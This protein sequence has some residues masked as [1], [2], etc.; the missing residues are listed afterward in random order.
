[1]TKHT[2]APE[3]LPDD[4][5]ATET[6]DALAQRVAKA[7][8]GRATLDA[9]LGI[10][11][12][13]L[14]IGTAVMSIVLSGDHLNFHG[15]VHGGVIFALA[16]SAFAYACN[17]RGVISVAAGCSIEYLC[18][19]AAGEALTATAREEVLS[20]RQGIY[21]VRITNEQDEIVALFR[22]KSIATREAISTDMRMSSKNLTNS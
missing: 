14:E 11:L 18:P 19:A 17:S 21:D 9:C 15:S 10:R 12:E 22:G 1:M 8:E 7:L 6:D 4:I 3:N 2:N 16:D 5:S 20:G 13:R